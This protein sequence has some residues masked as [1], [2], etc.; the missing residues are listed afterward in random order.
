M[1]G[2]RPSRRALL[3]WGSLAAALPIM[4]ACAPAVPAT[5]TPAPPKPAAVA[6]TPAPAAAPTTAP[7]AAA[8]P[9]AVPTPPAAA[10][11][12]AVATPTV[13]PAAPAAAGGQA[14]SIRFSTWIGPM[15]DV[16]QVA[17]EKLPKVK[18]EFEQVPFNE[19][20]Q[21]LQIALA[22]G[23]APDVFQMPGT[24]WVP[25][26]RKKV[27]APLDDILKSRNVD[28]TRFDFAP[29]RLAELEGKLYGVPVHIPVV[30]GLIQN[31][32]LF[33]A[34]GAKLLTAGSTWDDLATAAKALHKPPERYA[35]TAPTGFLTQM[36]WSNGGKLL[37]DDDKKCLLD[38]AE[39]IEAVTREV[40]WVVKEKVSMAPGEEKSL[41]DNAFASEKLGMTLTVIGDWG[42]ISSQSKK[43][44]IDFDVTS[45][46]VSPKSKKRLING[47][48]HTN[49]IAAKSKNLDAAGD[50]LT[51]LATSDDALSTQVKFFPVNYQFKKY[52]DQIADARQK[53]EVLRSLTVL[54][55][56][57]LDYWGPKPSE[58][59]KAFNA[60]IDAA[61][62]GKKSAAEAMK[63]ATKNIN[64]ILA[65][66]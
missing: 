57:V 26:M 8:A 25:V 52:A 3:K 53:S 66:A 21:K 7:A 35:I 58:S 23:T 30:F 56:T 60:E 62:L 55:D 1:P 63:E 10:A 65:E 61:Y 31:K 32:K 22:S 39:A 19:I 28:M 42:T 27:T 16:T 24:F 6:P 17:A 40:D 47:F 45:F 36:I 51:W 48:T 4:H 20:A 59:Q 41:G 54:D 18:V 33:D 49:A 64:D 44:A 34:A 13:A 9:T 43:A 14:T 2:P 12:T 11:P 5:P 38:S 50:F 15:K 29:K 46:P 37:S